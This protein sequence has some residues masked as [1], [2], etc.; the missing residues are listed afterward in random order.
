METTQKFSGYDE[1]HALYKRLGEVLEMIEASPDM[2]ETTAKGHLASADFYTLSQAKS[3]MHRIGLWR[4]YP[5]VSP[6]SYLP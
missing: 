1:C 5:S 3:V 6:A 2:H 4:K